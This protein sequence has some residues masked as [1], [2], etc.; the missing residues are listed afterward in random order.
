MLVEV[1]KLV[2]SDDLLQRALLKQCAAE[3]IEI[4]NSQ[5]Q[6]VKIYGAGEVD[7]KSKVVLQFKTADPNK[8]HEVALSEQSVLTALITT[9]KSFSVPLPR[10]APKGL[11]WTSQG[12]AMTMKIS[13]DTPP[14]P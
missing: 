1:R 9:C 5:V 2:F 4:P 8:P 13:M 3:G 10:S 14:L 6:K 12:L 11:Q 7:E